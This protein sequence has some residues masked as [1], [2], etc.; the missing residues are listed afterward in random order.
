VTHRGKSGPGRHTNLL[1][2]SLTQLVPIFDGV[3]K[4]TQGEGDSDSRRFLNR[5]RV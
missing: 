3:L 4:T 1:D 2:D 5:Q